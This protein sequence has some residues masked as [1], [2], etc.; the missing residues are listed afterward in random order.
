MWSQQMNENWVAPYYSAVAAGFTIKGKYLFVPSV[1]ETADHHAILYEL[2]ADTGSYGWNKNLQY[3]SDVVVPSPVVSGSDV[4]ITRMDD[5]GKTFVHRIDFGGNIEWTRPL[6]TGETMYIASPAIDFTQVYVV[7]Q[8]ISLDTHIYC[9]NKLTG[10]IIWDKEYEGKAYSCPAVADGKLYFGVGHDLYCVNSSTG[11]TIWT[12]NTLKQIYSSP[13]IASQMLFIATSSGQIFAFGNLP[14]IGEITGGLF[15]AKTNFFNRGVTNLTDVNWEITATG[16]ILNLINQT[17]LGTI[18]LLEVNMTVPIKVS[19]IFGLGNIHIE[20]LVTASGQ[21]TVRR[22]RNG[23][24]LGP[25][26]ILQ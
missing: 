2:D 17:S 10:D 16:G 9:L 7:A 3:F 21:G 14:Q 6:Q 1:K 11:N 4:Y 15:K 13:A 12:F 20:V 8:E 24:V 5:D 22:E 23:F 25:F 19:P 18:D 26:V